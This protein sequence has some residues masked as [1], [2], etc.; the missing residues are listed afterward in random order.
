MEK[1]SRIKENLENIKSNIEKAAFKSGRKSSDIKLTL[2][3]KNT[4]VEYVN[5]AISLGINHIGENRVQEFLSKYDDYDKEDLEIYFIGTL[6]TNKVKYIVDKVDLIESVNSVKLA[7][8]IDKQCK[9]IGKVMPILVEV[10]IGMEES[11]T[12]LNIDNVID[13]LEIIKEFKNISV[14][15]LMFI[16]PFSE[17]EEEKNHYV[18]EAHKLYIDIMAK[19]ID[20]ISMQ[21]LSIGM[22]DDYINAI[23]G[24]SNEVRIGSAVFKM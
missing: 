12:G 19:K 1:L 8:E 2:V 17:T 24:G 23:E 20:N 14:K 7:V 10:N 21:T 18:S 16:P 6:Q 9:K 3:T 13:M 22:S 4:S 5:Y 15:G 11:K